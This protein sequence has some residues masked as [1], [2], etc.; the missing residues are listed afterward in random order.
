MAE[1][2]RMYIDKFKGV[3]LIEENH[4][5]AVAQRAKA[6]ATPAAS[7]FVFRIPTFAELLEHGLAS[8]APLVNGMPWSFE[9]QGFPVS[10]EN[11]DCYL[12][13]TRSD[14]LRIEREKPPV[15]DPA[16]SDDDLILQF[17]IEAIDRGYTEA[18]A[19]SI[20]RG[21]LAHLRAGGDGY[22]V[23]DVPPATGPDDE[24]A[25]R[26]QQV[27]AELSALS[28]KDLQDRAKEHDIA[29]NQS[30]ADLV[31]QI[32]VKLTTPAVPAP[33]GGEGPK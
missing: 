22:S 10:H 16:R 28:R 26:F 17:S 33:D 5:L 29:A 1:A 4:P 13:T 8:G 32:T 7:A 27:H 2:V 23:V 24:K 11:D 15:I 6:A 9:W 3:V 18:A 31:E 30:S 20:A 14:T 19:D 12:I 25:A 21:R